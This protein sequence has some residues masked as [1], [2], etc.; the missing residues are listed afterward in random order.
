MDCIQIEVETKT[1]AVEALS[2]YIIDELE[3]GI[4]ICDPKD[5]IS[6]DKTQV[7]YDLIDDSLLDVDMDKVILK[8]YFNVEINIEDYVSKISNQLV[9]I[10]QFLDVGTGKIS[11]LEIPEEKWAHEWKKYYKVFDIGKNIVKVIMSNYG[12][13]IIDLGKDVKS[14][15]VLDAIA[16]HNVQLVGL[17][18][19]M[20]TTVESM[21][22][23]I[24][25][26][27]QHY[28]QCQIFVG[29]AVLTPELAEFVSADFY[30]KDA[31]EAVRIAEKVFQK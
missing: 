31:M 21:K 6:Q 19:L 11:V 2:Y 10:S 4:E 17:S 20:T 15:A 26:V 7:W 9:H 16:E 29:G 23:T 14:Q 27:R 8:A 1:E 30:A 13:N 22:D 24:A 5:V 18:A 12:F 3:G 28:P 25:E